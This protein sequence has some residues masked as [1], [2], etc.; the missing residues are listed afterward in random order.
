MV[1]PEHLKY[2]QTQKAPYSALLDRL[3][4]FLSAPD[5]VL[6]SIGFSYADAHI[7]ARIDEG[8]AGNP[9]A[10]V[11]AFQYK[12]LEEENAAADL[13]ARRP[14]FSVYARDRAIINGMPGPWVVPHELPS[15][16]WAP[17]R[18]TYWARPNAGEPEEFLLGAIEPFAEFLAASRS[19]QAFAAPVAIPAVS[20][21]GTTAAA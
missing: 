12:K 1:F 14:N 6:M 5:T 10:S 19:A 3:K 17:I 20:A 2:D 16:D 7:A 13:A 15:K 21:T 8:L 18:Q 4:A 9:G 11:F